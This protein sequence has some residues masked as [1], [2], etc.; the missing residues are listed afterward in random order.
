MKHL[1]LVTALLSWVLQVRAKAVFAHFMVGNTAEYTDS[2]WEDDINKAK[3]AHIDAFALNMAQGEDM[4]DKS[5]KAVFAKAEQLGFQLFFSFDY[6]GNGPWKKQVV[7]DMIKKY[8]GSPAHFHHKGKPFVSTFEGP[9]QA[10][11]WIDIK[12]QTGC[13][14]VPDWSSLGAKEAIGRAG[15][16]A[17]GLFSWDAWAWGGHDMDTY[18]DASYDE[19]L[20]GKPYM[21][22]VSPWFYTNMPGFG[23]NWL[24]RGDHAWYDRWV[25]VN[26]W[27]P[28]WVQII[29]WNDYGESHHI[30]PV[31]DHALVAFKTGESPYNYALDRPHDAWRTLLPFTIDLYKHNVAT[32]TQE[33]VEFWY[34]RVY[35]NSCN[36]GHT[37][38]NTASQVQL[39][40]K[41]SALVSDEVFFSALLTE[42]AE[43]QVVIGGSPYR[44]TWRN[45]PEGG[46]GIYHGGVPFDGREGG[47]EIRLI[48]GGRII[49]SVTGPDIGR[50][51]NSNGYNNFNPTTGGKTTTA[52]LS[53]TVPSLSNQ[54]CIGGWGAN[55][56]GRLCEFT[57]SY[58]YCPKGACVC[59]ALGTKFSYP[60]G[61]GPPGYALEGRGSSY[62]GL[63]SSACSYGF[64]PEEA[65]GL[66][67]H[68]LVEPMVSP[69]QPPACVSGTGPGDLAALCSFT[70]RHGY[71]PI[72]AC[73][74]TSQGELDWLDPTYDIESGSLK[75]DGYGLCSFA[76]S[77]GYCPFDKCVQKVGGDK[78]DEDSGG[79][80][81]EV[82]N[83]NQTCFRTKECVDIEDDIDKLG[84][85]KACGNGYKPV[86]WDK[87]I[88][89]GIGGTW[90]QPICCKRED[91]PEKCL[92]R[93]NGGDCNGQCHEGEV[94]LYKSGDGGWPVESGGNNNQCSRGYKYFCCSMDSYDEL[95]ERCYWSGCETSCKDDEQ[96]LATS[97]DTPDQS[98]NLFKYMSHYCCKTSQPPLRNCHWVGK[99]DCADNTCS[100]NEV[101]L[102][103]DS[104]GDSRLDC[105]WGRKKALCCTPND[106][107][108]DTPTC[109][110]SLCEYPGS[111]Y[112]CDPDLYADDYSNEDEC[113]PEFCDVEHPLSHFDRRAARDPFIVTWQQVIN[114]VV[115]KFK[116]ELQMRRYPGSSN[117]HKTTRSTPASNNA[118]RLVQN[119]CR[120][121]EIE[122]LDRTTM[123]SDHVR[124]TYDTEHNPDGQYIRDFVRTLATAILPDGTPTSVGPIPGPDLEDNWN[125]KVLPSNLPRAGSSLSILTPNGYLFDRLGSQGNRFP[126]LLCERVMNQMKGRIFNLRQ[127]SPTD[128]SGS[129]GGSSSDNN[130]PDNAVGDRPNPASDDRFEDLLDLTIE[131]NVTAQNEMFD[132]LRMAIGV[133]RYI[134]HPDALPTI[135]RNRRELRT[136]VIAIAQVVAPLRDAVAIHREFDSN[137]YREGADRTRAWVRQRI[138]DVRG[139]FGRLENDNESPPNAPVV[140]EILDELN[141]QLDYI[142]PPPDI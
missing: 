127:Q 75:D 21:M 90:G 30:G 2:D 34:R 86:G 131:G 27:Q 14:F 10:D 62:A 102:R 121:T 70:C 32:I 103:T 58:A 63:C 107:V 3:E 117:L 141:D 84:Y 42:E 71:C 78:G 59:T 120:S 94:T 36:D 4:N 128:S 55:D 136:A 37:T 83:L 6:A 134:N 88:C 85:S 24:W 100:A 25:Q 61:T 66:T 105:L 52:P 5:V 73:T 118:F 129:G 29:S 89:S 15:G 92:W 9:A 19:F 98:C 108:F 57:C 99:G 122:V 22:P 13:F 45:K 20:G 44:G 101:T 31:R 8:G 50:V 139:A 65:C 119:N 67:Q 7:I 137:W 95:T 41:P 106:D 96:D 111:G 1:L 12:A 80:D 124:R 138:L 28:E 18:T 79:R 110:K 33:S 43:V 132:I 35:K 56:F 97:I 81:L 130:D 113:E 51:C 104:L 82:V 68:P 140:R 135:Q 53:V 112:S 133:F 38:G 48:R 123:R 74:C 47:V 72:A 69:F 76:C 93:G 60:N 46:A 91:A 116:L 109:S 142:K 54:I 40:Y 26:W 17:D 39:E 49:M 126:L 87:S 115:R 77:R 114:N 64:C 125:A 23:K 16:V 11:D